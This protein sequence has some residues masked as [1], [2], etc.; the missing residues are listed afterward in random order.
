MHNEEVV[1][2]VVYPETTRNFFGGEMPPNYAYT[3]FNLS[4]FED[5]TI[6]KLKNADEKVIDKASIKILF[7]YPLGTT[8]P[9]A[10]EK[11]LKGWIFEEFAPNGK[12]FS[13]I[14]I[15]KAAVARYKKH[16]QGRRTNY[17]N[18]NRTVQ[19]NTFK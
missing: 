9:S 2:E 19:S 12:N 8:G 5:D 15:V 4:E 11:Q 18:Q 7:D 6:N 10:H 17:H 14:D 3:S 1:F 16:I 13:R